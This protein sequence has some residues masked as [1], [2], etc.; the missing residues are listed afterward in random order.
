MR[1]PAPRNWPPSW[2]GQGCEVLLDDRTVSPGVKFKDAELLGMPWIV[3]VG[4]GWAD[5]TAELR[6][7]FTGETRDIAVAA[8]AR[9]GMIVGVNL[10][11]GATRSC[12]VTVSVRRATRRRRGRPGSPARRR[13]PA[14]T[15]P[16]SPRTGSARSGRTSASCS[17]SRA[18]S[19]T[20]RQATA[21][22]SLHPDRE[23]GGIAGEFFTGSAVGSRAPAAAP[24]I[25]ARSASSPPPRGG[26]GARSAPGHQIVLLGQTCADTMP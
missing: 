3:V 11:S 17:E 13:A 18:C 20:A 26:R 22:S 8:D 25:T 2:T 21:Q 4:R 15:A 7:R 10:R 5:G 19:I 14:A 6:N 23:F 24:G 9:P 16:L 12:T 1:A